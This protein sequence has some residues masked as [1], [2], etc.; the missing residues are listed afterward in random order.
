MLLTVSLICRTRQSV[1]R[2]LFVP[3]R[4]VIILYIGGGG[5]HSGY[6]ANMKDAF[7]SLCQHD[8]YNLV[9]LPTLRMHFGYFFAKIGDAFGQF[10]N[11]VVAFWLFC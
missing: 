8:R 7:W 5:A 9:I 4:A 2:N 3:V 1:N 6:F 11:M 10:A